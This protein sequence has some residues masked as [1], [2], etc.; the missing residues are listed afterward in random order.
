MI[1]KVDDYKLGDYE[2]NIYFVRKAYDKDDVFGAGMNFDPTETEY[3][4]E[5]VRIDKIITLA[6][7]DFRKFESDFLVDN[8]QLEYIGGH[9]GI[10]KYTHV[11]LVRHIN[12]DEKYFVN[13]EG[14]NYARYVG[15]K[16]EIEIDNDTE[17]VL[18][19]RK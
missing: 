19:V 5:R 10:E 17:S 9:D 12:G 7:I 6:D 15:I 8:P 13:T 11:V 2:D 3:R 18:I 4:G 14:Y 1:Q 16:N